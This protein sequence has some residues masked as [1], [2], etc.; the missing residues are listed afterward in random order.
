MKE[1]WEDHH[2]KMAEIDHRHKI[3]MRVLTTAAV[4]LFIAMAIVFYKY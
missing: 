2:R 3:R 4:L 1:I